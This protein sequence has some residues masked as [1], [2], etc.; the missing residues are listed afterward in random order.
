MKYSNTL[1]VATATICVIASRTVLA[2]LGGDVTSVE[3]DRAK[4]KAQEV[5]A[6]ASTLYTIHQMQTENGTTVREFA[7]SA[8]VVFAVTWKGPYKPDLQQIL[9]TYFQTYQSAP[10]DKRSGRSHGIVE[11]PDLVVHSAGH[12]RV[13]FGTAYLPQLMPTG[14][15]PE[16]LA[17]DSQ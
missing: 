13:F 9:G 7:T 2:S 17:Q 4:M 14:V 3:S 15:T 16:T 6:S 11:Q 1:I 8:G 5:T 12:L 10:R